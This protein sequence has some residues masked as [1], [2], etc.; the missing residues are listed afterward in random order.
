MTG[1]TQAGKA[2]AATDSLDVGGRR[3]S[4]NTLWGLAGGGIP[5]LFALAAMPFIVDGLGI[6]R[7]GVLLLVW[8]LIGYFGLTD[9]GIGRAL[10]H[11][12]ADRLGAGKAHEVPSVVW[13]GMAAMVVLGALGGLLLSALAGPLVRNLL[14]VPEVYQNE[15]VAC[16]R[17]VALGLPLIVAGGGLAG[18]LGGYQRFALINGLRIPFFAAIFLGQA[19][20]A[21]F[22]PNLSAV[23]AVLIA[24]RILNAAVLAWFCWRIAPFRRGESKWNRTD[25]RRLL[26]F[27]G[28]ITVSNVIGPLM[29]YLD[30]FLI[31]AMIS[32]SA[33][34]YYATPHEA[35][36]RLGIVPGAVVGVLFPA[37]ASV[38]QH[39]RARVARLFHG[40]LA[41]N[42]MLLVPSTVILVGFA[43]PLL[44]LWLGPDFAAHS[45][46]VLQV[47][48]VAVLINSLA[49][50]PF[51]LVQALGRP[52]L[53]AKLHLA[54]LLPYLLLLAWCT[55]TWGILGA[56]W[57]WALRV[58][59]DGWILAVF[60]RRLLPELREDRR[61]TIAIGVIL[62]ALL[63]LLSLNLH[64][65][66][67]LAL[68][69]AGLVG[70][71]IMI[72]LWFMGR[73]ERRLLLATWKAL[74]SRQPPT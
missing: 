25:L 34:A 42:L 17:L 1:T 2:V 21:T 15:A 8:A 28:W 54:E 20:V 12:T 49:Q 71:P 65:T 70:A 37:F 74:R 14:A 13:S 60:A 11:M 31:G 3:L 5:L 45:T 26:G 4:V 64:V 50:V 52:D 46:P 19:L 22:W 43:E 57:V 59:V 62:G 30:R 55:Q 7:F 66:V 6:V 48:A 35:V 39:D 38:A 24:I 61:P 44:N 72:W 69:A 73:D 51:A 23:V 47:M 27:G 40:G 16:L 56:A 32:M 36:T 41:A 53:T 58:A 9:L 10:T 29:V 18:V 33:V 63:L 67:Q 68:T